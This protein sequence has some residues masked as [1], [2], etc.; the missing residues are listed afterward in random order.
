LVNGDFIEVV[1]TVGTADADWQRCITNSQSTWTSPPLN[2][3]KLE[4]PVTPVEGAAPASRHARL[5]F[6]GEGDV[7]HYVLE[8]PC[9]GRLMPPWSTQA[10]SHRSGG[11]PPENEQCNAA[12]KGEGIQAARG[13]KEG[14][15]CDAAPSIGKLDDC[16]HN[17]IY[18]GGSFLTLAQT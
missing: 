6:C 5:R 2:R 15:F 7:L 8:R 14:F 13:G 18:E 16:T 11:G 4:G 1:A 9:Q 17:C 3:R 10:Q 12:W